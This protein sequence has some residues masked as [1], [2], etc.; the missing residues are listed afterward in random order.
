[1]RTVPDAAAGVVADPSVATL[2]LSR[3]QGPP[4]AA[5]LG[6]EDEVQMD[7]TD[8]TTDH[9]GPARSIALDPDDDDIMEVADSSTCANGSGMEAR[10]YIQ[11]RERQRA[12]ENT[13]HRH[14]RLARLAVWLWVEESGRRRRGATVCFKDTPSAD[15]RASDPPDDR[16]L[17]SRDQ[18]INLRLFPGTHSAKLGPPTSQA[19]HQQRHLRLHPIQGDSCSTIV[20]RLR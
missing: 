7:V 14:R 18:T 17:E 15:L 9:P 1:M 19:E 13:P 6:P 12:R 5:A 10:G 2:N 8:P 11:A 3:Q 20:S 4:S 16:D